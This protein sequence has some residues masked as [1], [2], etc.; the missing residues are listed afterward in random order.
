ME[1][2][3][4]RASSQQVRHDE[5]IRVRERPCAQ[6]R[7]VALSCSHQLRGAVAILQHNRLPAC[8]L[9]HS[10]SGTCPMQTSLKCRPKRRLAAVIYTTL[11]IIAFAAVLSAAAWFYMFGWM[12]S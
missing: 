11:A 10:K 4:S 3:A 7:V 8:L 1:A 5:T 9:P 2:S 12:G 6:H